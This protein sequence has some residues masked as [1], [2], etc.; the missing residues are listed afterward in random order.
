M[1]K[2]GL[3]QRPMWIHFPAG[4]YRL[5]SGALALFGSNLGMDPLFLWWTRAIPMT[6]H[7][8][9]EGPRDA[10]YHSK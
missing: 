2:P 5:D 9:V 6:T 4:Y 7:L 1:M 8:A 3:Y 10:Q